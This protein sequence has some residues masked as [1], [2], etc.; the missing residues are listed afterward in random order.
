MTAALLD[1]A[2]LWLSLEPF[3]VAAGPKVVLPVSNTFDDDVDLRR[4]FALAVVEE[5]RRIGKACAA[6]TGF[7][8][9]CVVTEL[10]ANVSGGQMHMFD[11]P[12]AWAAKGPA[13]MRGGTV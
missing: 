4:H 3:L 13:T 7:E 5:V 1:L 11:R 2:L 12:L 10:G 8:R 6:V 9:H